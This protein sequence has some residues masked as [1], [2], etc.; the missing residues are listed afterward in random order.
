MKSCKS[1]ELTPSFITWCPILLTP[2]KSAEKEKNLALLFVCVDQLHPN[3]SKIC[4]C[5]RDFGQGLC[6][7]AKVAII[8]KIT[9]TNLVL[10]WIWK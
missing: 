4:T 8:Q 6:D 10:C 1:C 3:F 2:I 9:Q 5:Q 7:V